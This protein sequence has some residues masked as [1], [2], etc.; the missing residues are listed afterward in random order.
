MKMGSK[1]QSNV[2]ANENNKSAKNMLFYAQKS[3]TNKIVGGSKGHP[4]K[5]AFS[6]LKT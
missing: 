2:N 1:M 3:I 4:Q 6:R 5:P